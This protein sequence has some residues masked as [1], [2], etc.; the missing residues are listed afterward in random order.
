MEILSDRTN[1]QELCVCIRILN[2]RM[3]F[4][5]TNTIIID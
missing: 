3:S 2:S 1:K 5:L 4:D